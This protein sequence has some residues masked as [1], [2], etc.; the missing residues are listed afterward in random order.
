VGVTPV[1]FSLDIFQRSQKNAS[2]WSTGI[3]LRQFIVCDE[4]Y[5]FR[6]PFRAWEAPEA[7]F[8]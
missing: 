7:K 8:K 3:A 1:N 4:F 2:L 5:H 6:F